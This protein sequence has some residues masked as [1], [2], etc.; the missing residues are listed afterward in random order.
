MQALVH[1]GSARRSR[2]AA[3]QLRAPPAPAVPSSCFPPRP[4]G[5]TAPPLPPSLPPLS[6]FSRDPT[7]SR[8]TS[9]P[10]TNQGVVVISMAAAA[11][12]LRGGGG[13]GGGGAAGPA[14]APGRD[15]LRWCLRGAAAAEE[16]PPC[17]AALARP[18]QRP[19]R[20]G[21]GG[22]G[23]GSSGDGGSA[24]EEPLPAAHLRRE[25]A[26]GRSG[27]RAPPFIPSPPAQPRRQPPR[28]ALPRPA[29]GRLRCCQSRCLCRLGRGGGRGLRRRRRSVVVVGSGAAAPVP[30]PLGHR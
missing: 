8:D 6:I 2:G 18:W 21:G 25:V 4:Q 27:P 12:R 11:A 17:C 3:A 1:V 23:S 7:A 5:L 20:R 10:A 13:G 30:A 26:A 14:P 9:R 19:P 28:S 16:G 24:G 22:G 15:P 29:L